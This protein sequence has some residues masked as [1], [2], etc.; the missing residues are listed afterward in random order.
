MKI[1]RGKYGWSTL[2]SS[3]NQDGTKNNLYVNV[4][5]PNFEELIGD[6]IEGEL[7][8]RKDNG[9]EKKCFLSNYKKNDGT[10]AIKLVFRKEA[11]EPTE[12]NMM[13]DNGERYQ[14]KL[15]DGNSDMFGGRVQTNDE[16]L[17][18]Y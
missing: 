14:T 3:N 16:E 18:F 6:E 17:P 4:Q 9:E 5:F 2:T 12:Q 15:N 13:N 10:S 1:Y 11:K 7:I 8:F